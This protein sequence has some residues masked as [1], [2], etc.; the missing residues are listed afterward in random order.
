MVVLTLASLTWGVRLKREVR[1]QAAVIRQTQEDMIR[2][3]MDRKAAESQA[4][5]YYHAMEQSPAVIVITNTRGDIEYVNPKFTDLSGY[6]FEEVKGKNPRVLKSGEFPPESYA[7]LW[8][9]IAGGGEWRGEFHNRKKN[10]ELYWEAAAISP[11][12]DRKGSVTHFVAVKE[13]ITRRKQL[14]AEREKLIQELQQALANVKTLSGLLPVCA[15]CKKVRD[16][17]G[18]WSQLESYLKSHSD[19]LITHGICPDCIKRLY[20]EYDVNSG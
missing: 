9:T 17:N 11:V 4:R 16:D 15:S 12:R 20:P 3:T 5:L 8:K 19:V 7:E 10:G 2:D 13:D 1:R 18:Y 6:S 14:E